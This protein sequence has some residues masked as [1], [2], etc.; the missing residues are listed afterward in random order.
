MKVLEGVFRFINALKKEGV[1]DHL[2]DE[3]KKKNEMDF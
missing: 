1:Q 3:L 2:F